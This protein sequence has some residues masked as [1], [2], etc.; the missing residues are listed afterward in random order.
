MISHEDIFRTGIALLA[1]IVAFYAVIARERKT[2]YILNSIYAIAFIV[3][4]SLLLSLVSKMIEQPASSSSPTLVTGTTGATNA[5]PVLGAAGLPAKPSLSNYLN[6][7][8]GLLLGFGIIFIFYRIWRIQNRQINFRNDQ[9]YLSIPGVLWLRKWRQHTRAKPTYE[10]NPQ[11]LSHALIMSLKSSPFIP[12]EKL[13]EALKHNEKNAEFSISSV[14]LVPTHSEADELMADLAIRFLEHD[15]FVQYTTCTRHPIEFLLHLKK[16][17]LEKNHG[18]D[19][20]K[21]KD[22]VVIVDGYTPHFG[23]TDTVYTEWTQKAL[24]DLLGLH[25]VSPNIRRHPY[26]DRKRL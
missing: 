26:R 3:L 6:R 10:H 25:T 14:C 19:W 23:F 24:P 13:D 8:A 5:P 12:A 9:L 20:K 17:W 11:K 16:T 2:P 18:D 4:A 22:R 1:F 15:C 21:V 7:A